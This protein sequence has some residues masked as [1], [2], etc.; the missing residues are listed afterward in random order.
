VDDA[1]DSLNTAGLGVILW[2]AVLV[3]VFVA[4]LAVPLMG[5]LGSK[6]TRE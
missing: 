6:R 4:V 3:V 5:L 2:V 1:A